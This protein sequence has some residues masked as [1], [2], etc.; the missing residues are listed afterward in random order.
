AP[1]LARM[2]AFIAAAGKLAMHVIP[3]PHNFARYYGK[4]IGTPELPTSAF[5]EFWSRLAAHFR[6]ENALWAVGL[7]NEPHD[8]LGLWPAAAQLAT[9][10]VRAADA[11]RWVFVPGDHWAVVAEWRKYN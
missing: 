1:E 9:D 7:M 4:L 8:T 11:D 2:D 5:A 6:G 3:S 10:A